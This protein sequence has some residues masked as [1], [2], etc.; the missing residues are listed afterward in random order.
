MV[1]EDFEEYYR[2]TGPA[3][4][5]KAINTLLGLLEGITA[6]GAVSKLELKELA[7]WLNEHREFANR[8]PFT[9]I[10]GHVNDILTRQIIDEEDRADLLWLCDQMR[11]EGVYYDAITADMQVL[12]GI[13][14]GILA[15][16]VID[17]TELNGLRAW[18]DDHEHLR[19]CWPF[20]EIDSVLTAVLKDKV[21]DENEHAQLLQ[22]FGEFSNRP[23]HQSIQSKVSDKSLSV[24]GISPFAQRS[25][26]R[27]HCF[28]SL[29]HQIVQVGANL[30]PL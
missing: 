13:L 26:S 2:Y 7:R 23:G 9:E 30:T 4:L 21:V 25:V 3:R 19:S 1:E 24:G 17:T 28:A 22:L 14:H 29:G 18:I 8:H 16:N 5:G 6:D 20:D 12:E 10:V 27:A 15:D 11:P